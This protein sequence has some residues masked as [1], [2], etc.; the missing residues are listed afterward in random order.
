MITI[1]T[2]H[3]H[4]IADDGDDDD[5]QGRLCSEADRRHRGGC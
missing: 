1:I 2:H 4:D 5:D 3:T